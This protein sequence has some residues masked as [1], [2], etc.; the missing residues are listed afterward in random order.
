MG[1][2]VARFRMT[3]GNVIETWQGEITLEKYTEPRENRQMTFILT[4]L[5]TNIYSLP[6]KKRLALF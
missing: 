6:H 4:V 5:R 3:H 1:K 2:G